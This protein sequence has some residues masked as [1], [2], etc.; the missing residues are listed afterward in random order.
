MA[1]KKKKGISR[2][3]DGSV[4]TSNSMN[5]QL[6]FILFLA[7]LAI[8]YI[9]NRFAAERMLRRTSIIEKEIQELNAESICVASMLMKSTKQSVVARESKRRDMGLLESTEPP[10]KIVITSSDI[11]HYKK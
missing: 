4:L 3:I 10:H 11:R 2:V 9:G 6:P 1:K 5:K 7:V 8:V